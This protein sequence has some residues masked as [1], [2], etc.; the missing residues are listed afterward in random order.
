VYRYNV[1]RSLL[2]DINMLA[3]EFP[4]VLGEALE[5]ALES[6]VPEPLLANVAIANAGLA[7]MSD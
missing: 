6:R 2:F 7:A 1:R 4:V 3:G 5:R